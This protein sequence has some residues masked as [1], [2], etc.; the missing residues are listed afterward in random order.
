MIYELINDTA[1]YGLML[2]RSLAYLYEHVRDF[3]VAEVEGR[4][5]GVCGLNIIW[6]N[7]AEVYSLVVEPSCRGRGIGRRLVLDCVDEGRRLGIQKLMTLTYEV[8]F[9]KACGFEITDRQQLPLKVWSECLRCSRNQAC[10][11][12]AMIRVFEDIPECAA[13]K[14]HLPEEGTYEVPVPLGIEPSL[15]DRRPRMDDPQ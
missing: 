11:E 1:E 8:E 6:S 3:R 4:V 2:H 9:F 7:L 12:V 5:G 10:D 14:P 13:P 15:A